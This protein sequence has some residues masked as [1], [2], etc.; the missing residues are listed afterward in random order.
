VFVFTSR[1]E[2]SADFSLPDRAAL[3]SDAMIDKLWTNY[4]VEA[5]ERKPATPVVDHAARPILAS[6]VA[7]PFSYIDQYRVA[8]GL[9]LPGARPR[10]AST[11]AFWLSSFQ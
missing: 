9:Q 3:L 5:L 7:P 2:G 4:E 10:P 1:S 11:V 6:I 8:V